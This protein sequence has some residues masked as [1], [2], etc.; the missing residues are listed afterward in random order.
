MALRSKITN[1][2]VMEAG[3]GRWSRSHGRDT[4]A[5]GWWLKSRQLDSHCSRRR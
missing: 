5:F 1:Q 4:G 2:E 3:S